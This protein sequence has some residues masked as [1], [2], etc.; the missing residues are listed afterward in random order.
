MVLQ[1]SKVFNAVHQSSFFRKG[2]AQDM[3]LKKI[4]LKL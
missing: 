2:L 4:L 3:G 1:I